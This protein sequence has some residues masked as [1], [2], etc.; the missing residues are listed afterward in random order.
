M[1]RFDK[2]TNIT[3]ANILAEQR[4]INED[5]DTSEMFS[6]F[7]SSEIKKKILQHGFNHTEQK[8]ND[9]AFIN[10]YKNGLGTTIITQV[11]WSGTDVDAFFKLL[12]NRQ[13][14]QQEEIRFK[15]EY[16]GIINTMIQSINNQISQGM[17]SHLKQEFN[18]NH[19]ISF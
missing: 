16:T 7:V 12:A 2:K 10:G 6:A 18:L 11:H 1:R 17:V 9:S 3:K 8:R 5:W 13:M 15:N 4:H 14:T 19:H